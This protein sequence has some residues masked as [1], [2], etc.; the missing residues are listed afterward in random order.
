MRNHLREQIMKMT[1]ADMERPPINIGECLREIRKVRGFRQDEIAA[2]LHRHINTYASVENN[3]SALKVPDMLKLCKF[4]SV[5]P[6]DLL[7]WRNVR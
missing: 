1:A 7:G 5:S 3:E 6:N 4:Y 2:V